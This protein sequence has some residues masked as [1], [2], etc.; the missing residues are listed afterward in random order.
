MN[1]TL[2]NLSVEKLVEIATMKISRINDDYICHRIFLFSSSSSSRLSLFFRT[3]R[4]FKCRLC[5]QKRREILS[6]SSSTKRSE[7]PQLKQS[8]FQ[9]IFASIL[10]RSFS[11]ST[12]SNPTHSHS[13]LQRANKQASFHGVTH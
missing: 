13:V 11:T 3:R 6:F 2:Q 7:K 4:R 9:I 5:R 12:A 8:C 10:M 1:R